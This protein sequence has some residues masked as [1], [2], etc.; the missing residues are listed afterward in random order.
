MSLDIELPRVKDLA[1][2]NKRVESLGKD[3][4]WHWMFLEGKKEEPKNPF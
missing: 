3:N 2:S 1:W 4:A